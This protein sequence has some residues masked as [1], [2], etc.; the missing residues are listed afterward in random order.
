MAFRPFLRVQDFGSF[1]PSISSAKVFETTNFLGS[2][3]GVLRYRI[4][5]L[6]SH[7]LSQFRS[8]PSE[9]IPVTLEEFC[10]DRVFRGPIAP[11][12]IVLVW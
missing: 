12:G 3:S 8:R 11:T 9:L 5:G 2:T 7:N 4:P 6:D 10:S 1:I